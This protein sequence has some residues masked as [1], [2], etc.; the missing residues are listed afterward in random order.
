MLLIG[1]QDEDD[2]V[3]DHEDVL[4]A[5]KGPAD[6]VGGALIFV[7][8]GWWSGGRLVHSAVTSEMAARALDSS[9]MVLLVA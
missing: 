5:W 6:V 2:G 3:T 8:S 1:A 9:T 7:V 4:L